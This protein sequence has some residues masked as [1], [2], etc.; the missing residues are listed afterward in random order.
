MA[1]AISRPSTHLRLIAGIA[2]SDPVQA[3]TPGLEAR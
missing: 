3:V 2:R 1:V